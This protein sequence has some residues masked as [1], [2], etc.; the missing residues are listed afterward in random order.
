MCVCVCLGG[1]GG[2]HDNSEWMEELSTLMGGPDS[3]CSNC[4][5]LSYLSF[6]SWSYCVLCIC[7]R[8]YI[9]PLL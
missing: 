1:G 9:V 5:G 6:L 8:K 7:M 3:G 2:E 4:L